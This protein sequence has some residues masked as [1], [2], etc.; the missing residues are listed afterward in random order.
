MRSKS[1]RVN[2]GLDGV[3]GAELFDGLMRGADDVVDEE[4]L[5]AGSTAADEA[6]GLLK[7]LAMSDR[8][9]LVSLCSFSFFSS[10]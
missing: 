9:L 5:E 6:W 4:L 1:L 8:A 2:L 7:K 10:F 3:N